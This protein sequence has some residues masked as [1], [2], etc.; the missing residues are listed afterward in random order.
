MMWKSFIDIKKTTSES[1]QHNKLESYLN[2]L[3]NI[4]PGMYKPDTFSAQMSFANHGQASA[5][6]LKI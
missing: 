6:G 5:F 1:V 4:L 2:I 3:H